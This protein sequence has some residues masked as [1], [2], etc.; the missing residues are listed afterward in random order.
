MRVLRFV[1]SGDRYN[2]GDCVCFEDV[3]PTAD[4]YLASGV[5]VVTPPMLDVTDAITE[6]TTTETP[7]PKRRTRKPAAE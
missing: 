4:A 1:V 2:S 6:V 3:D 7:M 5:A